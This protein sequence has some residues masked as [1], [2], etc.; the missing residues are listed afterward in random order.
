MQFCHVDTLYSGEVCHYYYLFSAMANFCAMALKYH[1]RYFNID[2]P[3]D[4][5]N[6]LKHW[7]LPSTLCN[8]GGLQ[9]TFCWS[10]LNSFVTVL[11]WKLL[12]STNVVN[13]I[14]CRPSDINYKVWYN[15]HFLDGL[16]NRLNN[17]M[18]ILKNTVVW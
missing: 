13:F 2:F 11:Q 16:H 1:W 7:M 6:H 5:W 12:K 15:Y 10:Y 17:N 8:I 18:F 4:Q 3:Q 14:P 9:R